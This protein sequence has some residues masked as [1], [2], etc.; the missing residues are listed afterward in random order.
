[1]QWNFNRDV[2]ISFEHDK[3]PMVIYISSYIS[4]DFTVIM[5]IEKSKG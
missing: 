3:D 5:F 1:M 4:E 2:K